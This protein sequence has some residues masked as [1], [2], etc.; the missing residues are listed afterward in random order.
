ME[1][2]KIKIISKDLYIP[3]GFIVLA[4]VGG[5]TWQ[6]AQGRIDSQDAR[7]QVVEK[8]VETLNSGQRSVEDRTIRLEVQFDQII[9]SLTEIKGEIKS[10]K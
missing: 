7:L 8:L 6:S 1:N 3:A 9:S 2:K 4:I 10:L 5:M